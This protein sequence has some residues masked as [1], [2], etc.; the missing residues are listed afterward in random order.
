MRI[1]VVDD[2]EDLLLYLHVIMGLGGHEVLGVS[3]GLDIDWG[4]PPDVAIV[5]LM[6]PGMSGDIV[7][8]QMRA[9]PGWE[10]V[11]VIL[12]S[13]S[14]TMLAK[15]RDCGADAYITKPTDAAVLVSIAETLA[16]GS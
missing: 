10:A 5:D 4:H 1:L 12:W 15:H 2:V 8:T 9:T 13:A 14:P 16:E 6:M 7:V 11:K 3:S